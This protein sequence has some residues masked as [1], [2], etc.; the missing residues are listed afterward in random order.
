MKII[1]A[2]GILISFCLAIACNNGEKTYAEGA[3][4]YKKHCENC[5][6]EDGSGF[7]GLYPPL[8]G[9]DMLQSMGPATACIIVNGLKGKIRVNGV[10]YDNEMP[11]IKTLSAVEV[12]NILNYIN[13]AWG[14]KAEYIQLSTI[15]KTLD[16]CKKD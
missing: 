15:T 8:A 4:L 16:N 3:V 13:S 5:H 11:A 6:M 12:T 10:E 9:A 2:I 7:E 14:N 1:S